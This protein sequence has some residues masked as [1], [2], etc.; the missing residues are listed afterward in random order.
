MRPSCFIA[1]ARQSSA[2]RI[3]GGGLHCLEGRTN[4]REA[5]ELIEAASHEAWS[6][7]ER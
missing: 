6:T 3:L 4:F 1:A 2:R 5:L 7:Q